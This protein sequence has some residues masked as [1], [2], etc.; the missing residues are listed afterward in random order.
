MPSRRHPVLATALVV[1]ALVIIA[2]ICGSASVAVA[3]VEE[4]TLGFGL[5]PVVQY[6]K[7]QPAIT[8]TP[9]VDLKGVTIKVVSKAG[10]I[11]QLRAGDIKAG[12]TKKIAVQQGKGVME[13]TCHISGKAGRERFGPLTFTFTLKVGSAPRIA[14]GAKDVDLA[15]HQ[16]TVRVSEPKGRLKLTVFGD[17]GAEL[18][19][20]EQPFDVKPGT[21]ITVKWKQTATQVLGRFV[22]RA[23]D[24]VG[25]WSGV[26]SV[27]FVNIP[28]DDIVFESGKW[29]LL[30]AEIPK[31]KA[32]IGR[33]V[34]ELRKVAGVLPMALYVGGYTDTVGKG[35]D[36]A[37]LSRKRANAIARWFAAKGLT[38]PIFYQGFG[39]TALA[40]PTPDGTDEPRNRRAAYVLA[41]EPPPAARGFPRRA[42]VRVAAAKGQ[43]AP[44]R[45]GR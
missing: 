25:F 44:R 22:L 14:I 29:D 1:P 31:L 12:R 27:T 19:E 34:A 33:I 13:Y 21:P 11:Q 43:R 16:L 24:T 4:D 15:A 10:K 32:P 40:V 18:D 5:I 30:P 9:G 6:G 41:T 23:F 3:E 28:H 42:W 45:K 8:L 36:N 39:E 20:I 35:P 26:E 7:Q 2:F 17:D 38:I 37:E